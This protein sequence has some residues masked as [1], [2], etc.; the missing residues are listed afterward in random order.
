VRPS[1]AATAVPAFS[2]IFQIIL[3]NHEY[4]RVIG[5]SSA[6]YFNSLAQQ[7]GL[8][9]NFYAIRHPSLP[10]YLALTGGDTFGV[11]SDCT[12]CFIDAPNLVDQLEGAGKSWKA[13]MEGMPRPCF[14]G[15]SG[16]LYRQKHNPFIYYNDVRLNSARCQQIVPFT[17]FQTD[18]QNNTLPAYVWITPNM[19][20]DEHDC[21]VDK[22][23]AW[24]K[25]W[26]PQILQSPAW[27][28][29]GVLFITYDEGS[30]AAGCCGN[31]AG[32][33]IATLVISPLGKASFQSNIAYTHYSLLRTIQDAWGL[34]TI[35]N[36]DAAN[37]MADF[38]TTTAPPTNTLVPSPP[39][40]SPPT[41]TATSTATPDP[42]A[43]STPT[44]VV[45]PTL[46]PTVVATAT[47]TLTP[48]VMPPPQ[49]MDFQPNADSYVRGGSYAHDNFGTATSLIVK[50]GGAPI[51]DRRA[52]LRFDLSGVTS[53]S[54]AI[55]KLYVTQLP[56]GTPAPLKV[57]SVS[58]A[59]WS[60]AAIRWDNQPKAGTVLSAVSI[61]A[62][63][64]IGIHVTTLVSG[65]LAAN[66]QV[67]LA[68]LDDTSARRSIELTSRESA[69]PP[70]LEVTP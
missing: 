49:A 16:S 69:S 70:V 44:S 32:G 26:V 54:R 3:E 56:N 62:P 7:Y 1:S 47:A 30:T 51:Y 60:E 21:G 4:D 19:C 66:N 2:H 42:S 17:A 65:Q 12:N 50:D 6:P 18:L 28:Q 27:Q 23:D 45:T 24:L 33:H 46:S 15:D 35:A 20:N 38:F 61:S 39:P 11:K 48:T 58:D 25:L 14:V 53:V 9:T 13:Y 37:P 22:G 40:T 34:G 63:G 5:N 52:F 8:A 43:T 57:V 59:T 55:L 41:S 29:N 36:T 31:A 64:W 67:S 10:N 68:L